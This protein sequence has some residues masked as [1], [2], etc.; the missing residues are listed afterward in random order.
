[1]GSGNVLDP[2]QVD[3]VVYVILLVDINWQ[4][5]G[6][7]PFQN[8]RTTSG[9]KIHL[10]HRAVILSPQS[11][12][13]DLSCCSVSEILR[14][15]QNDKDSFGVDPPLQGRR[16]ACRDWQSMRSPDKRE[17]QFRKC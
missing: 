1:M 3:S 17:M 15:A 14:W 10:T 2:S 6:D 13:K 11:R 8:A 7:D 16:S 4:D 5:P 12:E 9:I